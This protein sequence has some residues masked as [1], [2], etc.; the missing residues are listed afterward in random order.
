M[1]EF[2]PPEVLVEVEVEDPL[3]GPGE[4]LIEVDLVN[5]T[6]VETQVRRGQAPHPS[7]LP[8]L[9]V[10]PG[11]GVGGTVTA[12]GAGVRAA[13]LGTRV[14]SST[15][16]AGAYAELVPVPAD[17]LLRVPDQLSLPDGVALLADG[18]TAMALIRRV[19]LQAGETA[20]IEAAA[21][22][23]GSL[24]VQLA[25]REGARVIAVAGDDRKV[26]LARELGA[27]VALN[28]TRPTWV[29]ELKAD[30][31]GST[32][33][34]GTGH[35]D[36]V[37]DGVGGEI[38]AAAFGL[39]RRGGRHCAFGM[40]SGSFTALDERDARARG[41][42]VIRGAQLDSEQ[43]KRLTALALDHAAT[44]RL[45]PVIGQTFPLDSAADAH[46]AIEARSTLG[47]TLLVTGSAGS[48]HPRAA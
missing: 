29:S 45:H 47:K 25:K 12:V 32:P 14:V 5:V 2:G 43:R 11:N 22:G 48:R 42:T 20:L 38:G 26:Q 8:R 19:A 36:V 46:R 37:F 18:R 3:P 9:P 15:G 24:L 30:T 17:D 1:R 10:I 16:G 23:V 21:G 44:G 13:L 41:V 33:A 31:A 27:D 34:T 7:M 39:L 28:Y 6:F 35:V 4:V 40:A